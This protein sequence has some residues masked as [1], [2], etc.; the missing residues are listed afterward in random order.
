MSK[1]SQLELEKA[2]VAQEPVYVWDATVRI[3]HWVVFFAILTLSATGYAIGSPF[4]ISAGTATQRFVMGWTKIIHFYAAIAFMTALTVRLV[5]MFMGPPTARWTQLVPTT[6]ER[7]RGMWGTFKFYTFISTKPPASVGHNPLAGAAYIAVFGLYALMIF[8]GLALFGVGAGI[9][10]ASVFKS[11]LPL[12]G[13]AQSA[14]W[15]H[16]VGMWLIL[17]FAVQH[18]YSSVLMA[19][20]DKDATMDS[21]FSGYK[22]LHREGKRRG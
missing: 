11:F 10:G 14:R 7:M 16:H 4:V 21:I 9:S 1:A 15:L 12:L 18:V 20:V 6:R 2:I 22:S 17:G 19:R 3:V 5:W 13:G 8:T